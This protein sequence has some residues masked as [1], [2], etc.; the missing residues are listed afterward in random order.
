MHQFLARVLTLLATQVYREGS[1]A[2]G[3][4][5]VSSIAAARG[6]SFRMAIVPGL[7]D[8]C[9]RLREPGLENKATIRSETVAATKA[10]ITTL[11]CPPDTDPVIDEP[12]VV[13]LINRK[14]NLLERVVSLE[15]APVE[16]GDFLEHEPTEINLSG[17]GM[18]IRA[19]QRGCQVTTTTI[20]QEQLHEARDRVA[21]AGLAD[22]VVLVVCGIPLWVKGEKGVYDQ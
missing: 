8:C 12:A 15:Q 3:R 11:C 17:G 1:L 6:L 5:L 10:G 13:E 14:I 4:V 18:A 9:A 19:A 21:A 2:D 20:S 22:Q 7:V 16:N